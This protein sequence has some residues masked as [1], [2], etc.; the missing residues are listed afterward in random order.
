LW[1]LTNAQLASAGCVIA[2][3]VLI[4]LAA[5]QQVTGPEAAAAKAA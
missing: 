2:G 4:W 1:G 3:I 5:R